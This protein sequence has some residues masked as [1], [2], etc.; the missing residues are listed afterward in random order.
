MK[1][2][3]LAL[4]AILFIL[5]ACKDNK[6]RVA[7]TTANPDNEASQAEKNRMAGREVY[8]GIETGDMSKFNVIADDAVDHAGPRD[9]KGGDSIRQMLG[10]FR[11]HIKDM[12]FDIIADAAND[13]YVFTMVQLTGTALDNTMGAPAGTKIN[14]R[15]VDVVKFRNG[16]IVEHWGFADEREMMEQMGKAH[17]EGANA[18][19]R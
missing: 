8:K 16:K 12:K 19:N 10:D 2:M 4:I 13:D 1:K 14:G 9:R 18:K 3:L 11:K 5:A 7:S 17:M 6:T 15:H